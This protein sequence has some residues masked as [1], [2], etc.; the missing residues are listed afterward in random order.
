MRRG[1]RQMRDALVALR[2]AVVREDR[3]LPL[4]RCGRRQRTWSGERQ[5]EAP[6]FLEPVG[7]PEALPVDAVDGAP[8]DRSRAGTQGLVDAIAKADALDERQAFRQLEADLGA[9]YAV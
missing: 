8:V 9:R 1:A 4:V 7:H 6:Q 3:R 2:Q 5:V